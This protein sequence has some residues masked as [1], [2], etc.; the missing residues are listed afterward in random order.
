MTS[1]LSIFL[2]CL[3]LLSACGG[4]TRWQDTP[5]THIVRRGETLFAICWRY[6]K[7]PADGG[8]LSDQE[9]AVCQ[10][11]GLSEDDYARNKAA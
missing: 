8:A 9:K 5:E 1:R 2:C 11:L 4:G 6:G 7:D 3:L 10:T